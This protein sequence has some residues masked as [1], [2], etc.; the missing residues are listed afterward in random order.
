M[1]RRKPRRRVRRVRH[2]IQIGDV[3]TGEDDQ[4]E[5]GQPP[6]PDKA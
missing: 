2:W 5:V 4:A 1:H 6:D 3:D